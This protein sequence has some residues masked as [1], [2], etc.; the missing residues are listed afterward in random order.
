MVGIGHEAD[1][2]VVDEGIANPCA[3][4]KEPVEHLLVIGTHEAVFAAFGNEDAFAGVEQ[5]AKV[6]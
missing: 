2:G 4:L 6:L 1:L 3:F 5:L